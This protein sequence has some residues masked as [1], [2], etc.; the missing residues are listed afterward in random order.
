M[1]SGEHQEPEL[2][3]SE[4]ETKVKKETACKARVIGIG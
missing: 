1:A 2:M 4:V 3:G